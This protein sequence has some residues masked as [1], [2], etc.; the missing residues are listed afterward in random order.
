MF[1]RRRYC[2]CP[3]HR[4]RRPR[5]PRRDNLQPTCIDDGRGDPPVIRRI[6]RTN[7]SVR[8][9]LL[10][11]ALAPLLMVGESI[12]QEGLKVPE[13]LPD[14]AFTEPD[15]VRPTAARAEGIGTAPGR[16]QGDQ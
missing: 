4:R 2:D 14:W 3:A 8:I 7:K 9:A 10:L 16:A 15:K 11:C 1:Y 13:V 6:P 12:A 5:C